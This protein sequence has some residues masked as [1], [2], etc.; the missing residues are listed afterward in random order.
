VHVAEGREELPRET[1][2]R[3]FDVRTRMLADDRGN[4]AFRFFL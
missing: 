4:L 3:V 1:L 2:E